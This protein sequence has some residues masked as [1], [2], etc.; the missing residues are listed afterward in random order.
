MLANASKI[1]TSEMNVLV[2]QQRVLP[3]IVPSSS[4]GT[5]IASLLK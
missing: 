2:A 5:S 1:A 4:I 3:V